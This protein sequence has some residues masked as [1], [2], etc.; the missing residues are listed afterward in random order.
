[1]P[2]DLPGD[3][4]QARLRV[5]TQSIASVLRTFVRAHRATQM[6]L[7]NSPMRPK[8]RDDAREAFRLFWSHESELSLTVTEQSLQAGDREVFR[9]E[10]RSSAALPWLLYRDGL[11]H[12]A[13]QPGFEDHELDLLLDI[14]Q[15]A[16]DATTDDDDLVTLLWLADFQKLTFRHV[17]L[18][19]DFDTAYIERDA[20]E[21][22]AVFAAG[23][24]AAQLIES[25]PLGDGPPPRLIQIDEEAS[26]L[27]FLN[28]QE[29]IALETAIRSEY[30]TDGLPAVLDSLFDIVE[31]QDDA[32][33]RDDACDI[34]DRLLLSALSN[35]HYDV[36]ARILRGAREVHT[37]RECSDGTRSALSAI[38]ARLNAAPV[39]DGLLGAVERRLF[40]A[41]P[42]ALRTLL[43]GLGYEALVPLVAW[44]ADAPPTVSRH[45]I[46]GILTQQLSARLALHQRLLD[47]SSEPVVRGAVMFARHVASP[48]LV[49]PLAKVFRDG[50]DSARSGA[51]MALAAIAS[52]TAMEVLQS[53]SGHPLRD[54]RIAALKAI[55]ATR[56]RPAFARLL[57][58]LEAKVLRKVDLSEKRAFVEALAASGGDEGVPALDAIL[59]GRGLLGFKETSELRSCAAYGLGLIG[60]AQATR[61]LQR[62]ADTS[63]SLVRRAI[64]QAMRGAT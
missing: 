51:A 22:A 62:A 19:T 32:E 44:F 38:S 25:E 33:A 17:E 59:N 45:A 41:E 24:S 34:L 27:Y 64:S 18:L 23:P 14:L 26:T 42:Q 6:Y 55:A 54:V 39:I 61:S 10:E 63:D 21:T 46:E 4:E 49:A 20:G 40:A 1:M 7:P 56:Y 47:D 15:Q 11:R 35:E 36:V 28:P 43:E 29:A 50:A 57:Q 30:A 31:L 13:L 58:D 12:L 2:T 5:L 9:E 3:A 16:R 52:P 53:A 48:A 8:S 60:T 37:R